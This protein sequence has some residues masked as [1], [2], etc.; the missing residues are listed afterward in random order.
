MHRLTLFGLLLAVPLVSFGVSEGIQAYLNARIQSAFRGHYR[1]VAEEALA[2]ITLDWICEEFADRLPEACEMNNHLNLISVGA[3]GA[4]ATGVGLVF[5]IG[6][7]GY[8]ARNSRALLVLF[9]TPLVYLTAVTVVVLIAVHAG[10]A[11]GVLYYGPAVLF[12]RVHGG[13]ISGIALGALAGVFVIAR[14]MFSLIR[15]A[16]VS[17][18]GKT[19]T[20]EQAPRL[21]SEVD[22]LTQR[23][24]ALAPDH[25]V[26]GLDPAFFVTEAQVNCLSGRLRGRTLYCALPL[27]RILN[28]QE[29]AAIIGHELAHFKG[30]DTKF[31]GQFYPI[32]R[33]TLAA[34][35]GLEEAAEHWMSIALIPA[36][37]VLE[38][39]LECFA[40]AEK[41]LSRERELVADR[42]GA[43]VTTPHVMA[44]A[45]VKLHAFTGAWEGVKQAAAESLRQGLALVNLSKVYASTVLQ[46]ATPEALE[47]LAEVQLNHPTDSHPSL[48]VRL[49]SLGVELEE[50]A[51]D[52]LEVPGGKAAITLVPKASRL[53]EEMSKVYQVLMLHGG[54]GVATKDQG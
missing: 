28:R 32:Y 11:M 25:V 36:Y 8:L 14:A 39:L 12:G 17:V 1:A 31:S 5:L 19:L 23:L 33:G 47:G 7:A 29:L 37:V 53:E 21:W 51:A 3:L 24:G 54:A 20:R 50:V 49:R 46:M 9:F 27:S 6:A 41:R 45:L 15:R 22:A 52:A 38:Y 30:Q 2:G 10:L 16:S 18:I 26:V 48:W 43:I 44:T 34:L 40:L 13:I 42:A 35:A 4:A